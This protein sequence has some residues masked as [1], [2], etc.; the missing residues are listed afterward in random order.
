EEEERKTKEKEEELVQKQEEKG[1][2]E[3]EEKEKLM[4]EEEGRGG[5]GSLHLAKGGENSEGTP[6]GLLVRP[7]K[8]FPYGPSYLKQGPPSISMED[9]STPSKRSSPG[10]V[11]ASIPGTPP[12]SPP[13][14]ARGTQRYFKPS[15]QVL[16]KT[17]GFQISSASSSI[18]Q[19]VLGGASKLEVFKKRLAATYQKWFRVSCLSRASSY[20]INLFGV[21]SLLHPS[22]QQ[23]LVDYR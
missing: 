7:T 12:R 3:E 19:E 6:K 14:D 9:L 4:E 17:G 22:G 23:H 8:P 2:E 13:T 20:T 1:K 15:F 16:R 5:G 18:A 11:R 21:V 10:D